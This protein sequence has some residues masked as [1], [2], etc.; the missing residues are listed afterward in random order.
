MAPTAAPTSA[1]VSR[2][3]APVS[4]K[5]VATKTKTTDLWNG[6][7]N[8]CHDR[9]LIHTFRNA[10]LALDTTLSVA[11]G[12][13]SACVRSSSDNNSNAIVA[14][15]TT[16]LPVEVSCSLRQLTSLQLSVRS[17]KTTVSIEASYTLPSSLWRLVDSTDDGTDIGIYMTLI[18]NTTFSLIAL[19]WKAGLQ[20]LRVYVICSL[21]AMTTA[22]LSRVVE[23]IFDDVDPLHGLRG[24]TLALTMRQLDGLV[25]W[26]YEF[27][28]VDFTE[29]EDGAS[30]TLLG[31]EGAF[32][33]KCRV[34]SET[35]KLAIATDAFTSRGT[36]CVLLD[37]AVWDFE[38][39]LRAA[40][41]QCVLVRAQPAPTT[42]IDMDVGVVDG[43]NV[44]Q[45]AFETPDVT[46][47]LRWTASK[48][49]A[50]VTSV[51]VNLRRLFL[52]TTYGV[53]MFKKAT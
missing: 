20:V 32:R 31:P 21:P 33:D 2:I 28:A 10:F 17:S 6:K 13:G 39:T 48:K 50:I 52:A 27:Y 44:A 29:T 26:E 49:R 37:L 36:H 14:L 51:V 34:I 18:P 5:K 15:V 43:T 7:I 25:L 19:V 22:L 24:Y 47:T 4:R 46:C 16:T 53:A 1:T 35:P 3:S 30:V 42:T 8:R 9:A 38:K 45:V 11:I 40:T 12:G 41:S 23:P